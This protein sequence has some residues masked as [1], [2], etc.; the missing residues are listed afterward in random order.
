[1]RSP[2]AI[3]AT[4][5]PY[6]NAVA[7]ALLAAETGIPLIVDFRDPWTKIDI[8]WVISSRPLH[9]LSGLMERVILHTSSA[10]VMADDARYAK[11]FFVTCGSEVGRKISS[12]LNGYDDEDFA[13]MGPSTLSNAKFIISYVGVFYDEATFTNVK[14][15]FEKWHSTFPC[16]L[17]DVEL[18]YAGSG[19]AFFEK[20]GPLH[21]YVRDH[22]YVSH[23]EAIA[24]RAGSNLQLCF[25]RPRSRLTSSAENIRDDARVGADHRHHESGR[26]GGAVY[27]TDW[28]R[29]GGKQYRPRSSGD[30]LARLLQGLE[31][32]P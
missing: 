27:Q 28:N 17:H 31:G 29:Y 24:I 12:I 14:R 3:F 2:S 4:V 18:H 6:T 25:S 21:C 7:A 26:G 13:E 5:P 32:G 10:I 8:G 11:D 19:S 22:G 16:D 30:C 1:M 15:A 23:R 9:W 20:Y